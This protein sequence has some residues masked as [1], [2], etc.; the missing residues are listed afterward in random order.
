MKK[1]IQILVTGVALL[2]LVGCGSAAKSS[3][4]ASDS[5]AL[6]AMVDSKHFKIDVEWANPRMTA[7]MNSVLSSGLLPPGSMPNRIN[8]MGNGNFLQMK[9]DQVIADLPYWGERQMGGGYNSNKGIKFDGLAKDLK[10]T[11]N[12]EKQQTMITFS[13]SENSESYNVRLILTPNMNGTIFITSSQRNMISYWGQVK[14]VDAK[15]LQVSDS[16]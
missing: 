1:G 8:L 15:D 5:R 12:E 2:V 9:G 6:D 11:K 14:E 13:I 7:S 16:Q 3:A 4:S 10:I